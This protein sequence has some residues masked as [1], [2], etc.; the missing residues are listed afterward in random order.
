MLLAG[1]RKFGWLKMFAI[2]TMKSKCTLSLSGNRLETVKLWTWSPGPSRIPAPLLPNRP[3][4]GTAKQEASNHRLIERVSVGRLPLQ[5]RSGNPPRVLVLDGSLPEKLGEKYWPV[6][7]Y[8][9]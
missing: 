4:G 2:S 5:M 9:T 7:R 3:A 6:W 1:N 8:V